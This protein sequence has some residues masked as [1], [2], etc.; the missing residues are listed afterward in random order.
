M[1]K[2]SADLLQG[3]LDLLILK[4]LSLE[5]MNGWAISK[6]I[7]KVSSETLLVK[8]GSLYPC[9]HRL[10][11][12]GLIKAKWG[13]SENNRKAKFYRLTVRGRKQFEKETATWKRFSGS[14]ELVLKM[15]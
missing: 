1:S 11:R 2:E 8:Q 12:K 5:S 4:N 13:V 10:E 3:T 9:L 6:K 7:E 15:S 14:V